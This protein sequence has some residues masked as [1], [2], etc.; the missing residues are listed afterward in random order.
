MGEYYAVEFATNSSQV[1]W[2]N[3]ATVRATTT[4]TTVEVPV[5]TVGLGYYRVHQLSIFAIPHAP[6]TIQRWTNN[7]VRISWPLTFPDQT[8]QVAPS[9]IG[10]WANANLPVTV[11]GPNYVVYDVIGT[12]SKFYRLLP[13]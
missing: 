4:L 11:E 9:P 3:V 8:L 12:S 6:L 13:P 7:L 1:I 5:P 2:S 10:P